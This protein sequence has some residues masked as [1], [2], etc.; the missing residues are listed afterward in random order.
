VALFRRNENNQW[1]LSEY[2]LE[3][4]LRLEPIGVKIAIADLYR[5]VNFEIVS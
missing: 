4:N 3:D 5:Q 1:V 2:D